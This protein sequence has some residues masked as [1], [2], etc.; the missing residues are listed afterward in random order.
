MAAGQTRPILNFDRGNIYVTGLGASYSESEAACITEDQW[1]EILPVYTN[2]AFLRKTDQPVS[3]N[4]NWSG[5]TITFTP[6]FFFAPGETYHAVFATQRFFNIARVMS[7]AYADSKLKLSFSIPREEFALT[8]IEAIY[9]ESSIL[10]ANL[11]R[12]YIHFN[13][14]M[15]PGEAYDH[16][17]LFKKNGAIV[18]RAFLIVDQ[19]LWDTERKRFTLLFDPGRI[20]RDLKANID[21]GPP[22]SEGEKYRLVID[23]TW[24]DIHG[25]FLRRSITK[26]FSVSPARRTKVSTRTW[27]V[28]PP[29]TGSNED[30]II[31]FDRPM[32][33]ALVSKNFIINHAS[34]GI[35]SGQVQTVNDTV[36]RFTPDHPWVIGRYVISISPLVEDVAGNNFNNPFDVD[37]SKEKRVNSSEPVTLVFSIRPADQ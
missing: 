4:Y 10:P 26:T 22:L 18:E 32:D 27:R 5:D 33:H 8:S 37:L 25:S 6:T 23:S 16:I 1:K 13:A 29:L 21:L 28:S 3:G 34:S 20:K 7:N 35:I 24:R 30:L 2:E 31:S 36:L 11:L 19:E 9:P 14:P 17:K 12:M 15:M